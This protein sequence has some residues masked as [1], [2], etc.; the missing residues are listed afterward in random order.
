MDTDIDFYHSTFKQI[1]RKKRSFDMKKL[2]ALLLSVV[3]AFG[4][5]G[6]G[7][8]TKE[9]E[10]KPAN[11]QEKDWD[12]V[13]EDARGTEVNFYGWGGSQLTNDWIDGYLAE[14]LKEKY[15]ITLN[16]VSMD[17]EDI[18]NKLQSEK[19]MDSEG[20]MDVVWING[21][22]FYTA[23]T[24][25]LLYGSF[26]DKLPNFE[27]Y[28]DAEDPETKFDFGFPIEG[29]EAPYGKAQ[30]IMIKDDARME[31]T[32]S[33]HQE[34]LEYAK[35]NKGQF[36]YPAPPDF[37]GSA[38]VRNIIYDIVGYEQFM[39]MKADK[40]IVEDAIKPAIDYL[41][42]LKPYLWREGETYPATIAQLDNMFA[43]GQVAMSMSYT[44]NIV[45]SKISTGEYPETANS[46]V[47]EKGTIGNTHFVSIPFNAP[48]KDG[49]MAVIDY[50]MSPEAQASKYDPANWGDLPVVD[51][52][53][54]SDDEKAL[55]DKVDIGK[56]VLAQ[57]VLLERRVPEM[58][59]NL[60]P[61]IEEIWAENL[62]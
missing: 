9:A 45:A 53:K 41:K 3:M 40:A 48:N 28:I 38:F 44:P 8:E 27:K 43:D 36:T 35:Q 2:I 18:L 42:E 19:Q 49:A 4:M 39:D 13:L 46:F 20:T 26:T 22:N 24:N 11:T 23:K 1:I 10:E 21:E 5:A 50:I 32:L 61:I 31:G 55:F 7:S 60:V 56:G 47:F 59:A 25:E 54:M 34:L 12:A 6:C 30:L 29:Y 57:D 16:R 14:S 33:G 58:P 51:S 15:D 37:T 52:A 17:I 62:L